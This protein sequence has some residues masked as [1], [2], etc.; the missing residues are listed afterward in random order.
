MEKEAVLAPHREVYKD[1][2]K[3][4][5]QLEGASLFTKSSV[6]FLHHALYIAQSH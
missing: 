6:L 4:T 1:L 5:K 3:K 2:K